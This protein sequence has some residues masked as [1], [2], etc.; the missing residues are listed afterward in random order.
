MSKH[1]PRHKRWE[2]R[3]PAEYVWHGAVVRPFRGAWWTHLAYEVLP[4]SAPGDGPPSW[5]PQDERLGPFKRPRNAMVAAEEQMRFLGR[6]FGERVRFSAA[7]GG[8]VDHP[9]PSPAE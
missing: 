1:V 5:R 9:G 7:S 8:A 6:R 4:E 3:G 2:K